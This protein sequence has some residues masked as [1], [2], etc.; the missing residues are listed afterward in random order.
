MP[1]R[2]ENASATSTVAD[3]LWIPTAGAYLDTSAVRAYSGKDTWLKEASAYTSILTVFELLDGCCSSQRE[4][5]ARRG[6]V[7]RIVK[8]LP[9]A[10]YPPILTA[11]RAFPYVHSFID[12][13]TNKFDI[14]RWLAEKM[15]EI[16][17]VRDFDELQ[18]STPSWLELQADYTAFALG[19]IA[20]F[21][22][23]TKM[24]RA[25]FEAASTTDLDKL[26]IDATLGPSARM[27][28]FAKGRL[29]SSS[30]LYALAVAASIS[31][32]LGNDVDSHR[33]I[34]NSYN[35][36]S[37]PYV[38]ALSNAFITRMSRRELPHRN[39][40]YDQEHFAYLE[41]GVLLVTEDRRMRGLA[42][43]IHVEAVDSKEFRKRAH[44]AIAK[45]TG[46]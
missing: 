39:D 42:A 34:Y 18:Q 16:K 7:E 12:L 8:M 10:A 21:Q 4:Y 6:A 43:R 9:I 20:S 27:E 25:A 17:N 35:Q 40:L 14:L 19:F 32:G 36:L 23:Q 24:P 15:V 45:R 28:A 22:E 29:N 44:A 37:R 5:N 1:E 2:S 30:S 26:E 13:T 38:D 11:M 3:L 41:P 33:A 31:I 46:A